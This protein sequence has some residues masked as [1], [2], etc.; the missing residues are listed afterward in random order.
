M[1]FACSICEYTSER[2]EHIKKHINNKTKCGEGTPEIIEIQVEIICEHCNKSF[3]TRPNLKKHEKICKVKKSNVEEENKILKEKLAIAEALAAKA[4]SAP[5]VT[6]NTNNIDNSTNIQTQNNIIINITPYNDPN[7]EGAEKYYLSA[8]KKM[9]MSIPYI[10]EQIHFNTDFPENHNLCIK[11]YR[12]KLAKVFNGKEWKTMD[13]DVVINELIDT[14]ERL[15]EDWAEDKPTRMQYIE[16]YKEI[17]DRDGK[18]KVYK[19]LKDEVKK[20][21]YDKRDMIKIK[22]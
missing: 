6:N 18:S 2:K 15:L 11:N 16:R 10:I 12:T 4:T 20:L 5:A 17:K 7:L 19:D 3:K 22:N 13:E 9:F 14:Y 8:L 21:I 1:E